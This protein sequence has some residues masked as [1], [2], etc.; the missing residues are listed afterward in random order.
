MIPNREFRSYIRIFSGFLYKFNTISL[1]SVLSLFFLQIL[2]ATVRSF[3]NK[4]SRY[5]R[6]AH[7]SNV[8]LCL[9]RYPRFSIFRKKSFRSKPHFIRKFDS[10][11]GIKQFLLKHV[12]YGSYLSFLFEIFVLKSKQVIL[13]LFVTPSIKQFMLQLLYT[14]YTISD[15]HIIL[16][17]TY[18]F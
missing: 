5:V 9:Q 10:V 1:F 2:K 17:Y 8:V 13:Y 7:L 3:L 6:V 4:S 11:T 18:L 16:H 14:L 15:M 12:K